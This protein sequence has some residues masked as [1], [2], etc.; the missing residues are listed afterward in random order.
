[1]VIK[2]TSELSALAMSQ[3][4]I[5][6]KAHE[7]TSKRSK[8]IN[9]TDDYKTYKILLPGPF[10]LSLQET[11]TVVPTTTSLDEGIYAIGI[12]LYIIS[13]YAA[14]WMLARQTR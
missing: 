14:D 12:N 3:K 8:R 7:A 1:M 10:V 6:Q 2:P 5:V 4:R 11:E 9:A 13:K